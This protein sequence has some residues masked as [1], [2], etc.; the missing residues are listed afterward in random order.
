MAEKKERNAARAEMQRRRRET[1]I[2]RDHK[3]TV[4]RMLFKDRGRLLELYNAVSGRH[5]GNPDE[6]EI[7]TLENAIYMGI[8]ND[9]AFI[10]DLNLHMYEHQSTVNP[11]IPLRFLQ[12]VVNEYGRLTA[13]KNLFSGKLVKVPAPHFVVFYNG[14]ARQPEVQTMNLS[15]AFDV[16]EEE[17]MLELLVKVF[18]INAGFNE[19]LKK[20]C[21]TLGEY[22]NYVDRV[23]SYAVE[24]P[25]AEAV[26]RAVDE[27]IEQGI[28]RDFLLKNKAEVMSMDIFE[29]DERAT[30]KAIQKFEREEGRRE[31]KEEEREE[32][33][34]HLVETCFELQC[35]RRV[36]MEKLAEK[37]GL[38][39]EE[40]EARM[41]K[42]WREQ[43]T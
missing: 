20:N 26:E 4:F 5:Y 24:M 18:N 38:S 43:D 33:M 40:A 3:D 28:L 31:G 6:L 36:A 32:G 21:Q 27:C 16:P 7:V 11:N 8:K 13:G 25:T 2:R 23:R 35:P 1:G 39:G 14:E 10:I 42:Y 34:R 19:D 15:A 9:L 22:M 17:P 29:Y 30:R 12:Y 41:Q 37:Y